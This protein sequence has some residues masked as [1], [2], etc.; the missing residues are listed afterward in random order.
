MSHGN[1]LYFCLPKSFE[2]VYVLVKF[3]SQA[4]MFT[5]KSHVDIKKSAQ[6]ILDSRKELLTRLKHLRVILGTILLLIYLERTNWLST[7]D[8]FMPFKRGNF[9]FQK[10][11]W[12]WGQC[13]LNI[14]F[15]FSAVNYQSFIISLSWCI[16][17][18]VA[19]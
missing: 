10:K 16:K 1:V 12:N 9:Y 6:K 8:V 7:I 15:I 13:E 17:R 18:V 5:R 19:L 2:T 3:L 14:K 11:I 4:V